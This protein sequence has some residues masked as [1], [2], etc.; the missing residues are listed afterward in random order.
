MASFTS[1]GLL[2]STSLLPPKHND[3]TEQDSTELLD[4]VIDTVGINGEIIYLY[5]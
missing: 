5:W 1:N 3:V 4:G 2:G